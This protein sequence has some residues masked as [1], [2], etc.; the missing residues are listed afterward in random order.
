M[1]EVMPVRVMLVDDQQI[2]VSVLRAMLQ[3]EHDIAIV[4]EARGVKE[5]PCT[6]FPRGTLDE[7]DPRV[8]KSSPYILRPCSEAQRSRDFRSIGRWFTRLPRYVASFPCANA[9][10]AVRIPSTPGF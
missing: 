9:S 8:Y 1:G 6:P 4:G 7:S 10:R 5:A 2:I 3:V